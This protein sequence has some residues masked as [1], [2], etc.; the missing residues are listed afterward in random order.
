MS[1]VF[2]EILIP[3]VIALIIGLLFGWFLWGWRRTKISYSQWE[4]MRQKASR[5]SSLEAEAELVELRAERDRLQSEIDNH[6]CPTTDADAARHPY[7]EGSHAPLAD[8]PKATPAGYTIKGNADSMLYHR[9]DSRSY[10]VTIPEVWF[11]T[12]ERAEANGFT[13]ASSHPETD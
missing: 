9:P 12:A 6:V 11:D 5:S 1:F 7:G 10:A 3:L 13:L 4:F 2:W 8:D